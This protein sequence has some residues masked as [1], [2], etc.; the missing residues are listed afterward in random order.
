MLHR[1]LHAESP[2]ARHARSTWNIGGLI[3]S[4]E[5]QFIDFLRVR[6]SPESVSEFLRLYAGYR[7][8]KRSSYLV[9]EQRKGILFGI[10]VKTMTDPKGRLTDPI[11]RAVAV[12]SGCEPD[13]VRRV[14]KAWNRVGKPRARN[15]S[16]KDA[17]T[18][19]AFRW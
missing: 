16:V 11:A 10:L 7:I 4:K 14:W 9:H 2:Q 15:G 12:E 8:P 5:Q 18:P 19:E 6:M 1:S 17:T 3:V 13:H